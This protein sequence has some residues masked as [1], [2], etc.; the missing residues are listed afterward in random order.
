[1]IK[2]TCGAG[3]PEEAETN[4]TYFIRGECTAS[5]CEYRRKKQTNADSIRAMSDEELEDVIRAICIGYEPWCDHHCKMQGEDN[6]NICLLNW[7]QQPAETPTPVTSQW[8]I[9]MSHLSF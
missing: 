8:L 2:Y 4:C 7:L 3:T 6:C 1:M 9:L 5:F